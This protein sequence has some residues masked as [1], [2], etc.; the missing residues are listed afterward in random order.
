M[1]GRGLCGALLLAAGLLAAAPGAVLAE[2]ARAGGRAG[3]LVVVHFETDSTA[4]KDEYQAR[5]SELAARHRGNP[6][7]K[8]CIAGQA[9]KQGNA[10]YNE[11]LALRRAEAVAAYLE[12][13]GLPRGQFDISTRGEAFGETLFGNDPAQTDRR[14]EVL[15]VRY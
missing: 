8:V 9:D 15:V 4:I 5:L 10:A 2:C 12:K 13:Q 6:N 14:V 7:M 1:T 3:P 11:K